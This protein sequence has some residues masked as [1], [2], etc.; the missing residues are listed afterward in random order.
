ML[1]RTKTAIK[2]D[3]PGRV[4]G[5]ARVST[6]DQNLDGQLDALRAAGCAEILEERASGGDRARPVLA[7]LLR[8][9]GPGETIV[10]TRLDRFARSLSH[11]LE[12]VETLDAKQA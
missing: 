3:Y 6:E 8:Q 11:L 2:N 12:I 10:V 1:R 9:I 4:I 7:R 5:Y